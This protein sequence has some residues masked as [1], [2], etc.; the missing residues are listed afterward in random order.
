MSNKKWDSDWIH[1][2]KRARRGIVVLLLLFIIV[3]VSPRLYYNYFYS[4]PQ[5]D[6]QVRPLI[7]EDV[8]ESHISSKEEKKSR[9]TQPSSRFNPN[10]YS[11]E[12][13]MAVGL[14]EKQSASILKYLSRGANLRVKSDLKKLF[15]VDDELYSL[16]E[17]K[18]D[19]PDALEKT[20]NDKYSNDSFIKKENHNQ[21]KQDDTVEN[22]KEILAPIS[23]NTASAWDLKKI[24]GIGPYF[25]KEIIKIREAYGGLISFDQLFSVY[26]MDEEKLEAIKPFLII[27]E[28]EI[29]KLNINTATEQQLRNHPLISY[30]MAKSIVFFR[31]NHQP[32][33]RIDE[34]LLSPYIDSEKYK[35][36]KPYLKVE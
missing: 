7:A 17:P 30:D 26:L 20:V 19:L 5:Y 36:L 23:I 31:E 9:Y 15:V 34:V 22:E 25:A 16:L 2:S 29:N 28:G 32:Y 13:W 12:E 6:I 4:P 27:N 14:S 18:I 8:K 3:A 21:Q 10:D 33:K 11:L 24:P 35:G 1:F